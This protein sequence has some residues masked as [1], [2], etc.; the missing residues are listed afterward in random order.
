MS[1]PL[2]GI[3]LTHTVYASLC[4]VWYRP[5]MPSQ[6]RRT[7]SYANIVVIVTERQS[8]RMSKITNDGLTRSGT[9]CFIAVPIWQQ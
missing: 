3:F 4:Y 1:G 8:A 2:G 5:I 7:I 6:R 9:G